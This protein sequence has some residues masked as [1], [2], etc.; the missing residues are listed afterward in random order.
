MYHM[1]ISFLIVGQ[2]MTRCLTSARQ[3]YI[4]TWLRHTLEGLARPKTGNDSLTFWVTWARFSPNKTN[5]H[6]SSDAAKVCILAHPLDLYLLI[7]PMDTF[8]S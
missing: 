1:G 3:V 8:Q 7:D 5:Y 6:K 4:A 2:G